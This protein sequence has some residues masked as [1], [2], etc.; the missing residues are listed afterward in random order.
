MYSL[1]DFVFLVHKLRALSSSVLIL[2]FFILLLFSQMTEHYWTPQSNVSNETST[3][4]T[5]QRTISAQVHTHANLIP[6]Q[7]YIIA[8]RAAP[9]CRHSAALTADRVGWSP[10]A[11][12][13]GLR[14]GAAQREG[15]VRQQQRLRRQ[16]GQ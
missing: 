13:P 2:G 10:S 6:Q 12:H 15:A 8:H 16:P 3:N 4:K 14:H 1:F 7:T 5:F 11:G 9:D